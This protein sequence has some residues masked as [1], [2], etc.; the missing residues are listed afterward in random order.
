MNSSCRFLFLSLYSKLL[1]ILS[2]NLAGKYA[3]LN[4]LLILFFSFVK[5]V[6]IRF[7]L[8]KYPIVTLSLYFLGILELKEFAI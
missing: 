6:L 5:S 8:F 2:I 7:D 1:I 4:L 3:F